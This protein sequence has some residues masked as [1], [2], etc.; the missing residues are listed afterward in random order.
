MATMLLLAFVIVSRR[1][2]AVLGALALEPFPKL[3][4]IRYLAFSAPFLSTACLA[5]TLGTS[6]WVS[7]ELSVILEF[8]AST[9]MLTTLA[10]LTLYVGFAATHAT[11]TAF[12]M[13]DFSF[14]SI[15]KAFI[16]ATVP[17]DA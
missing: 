12:P 8:L 14:W 11:K 6:T 1:I 4:M 2:L 16:V 9:L 7:I 17:L 15:Q 13:C 5:I 3:K 10:I